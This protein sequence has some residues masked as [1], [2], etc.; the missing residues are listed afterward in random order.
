[1]PTFQ[2]QQKS[3]QQIDL[4][5]SGTNRKSPFTGC[6]VLPVIYQFMSFPAC[7][8]LHQ[9]QANS[10]VPCSTNMVSAFYVPGVAISTGN[11]EYA[12]Q[13]RSLVLHKAYALVEDERQ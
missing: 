4:R 3:K 10:F 6:N 8:F 1:M 9:S 2:V 13:A 5:T 11:K 12:K 7:L